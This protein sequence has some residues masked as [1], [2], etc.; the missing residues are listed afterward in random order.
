MGNKRQPQAFLD[1]F[2]GTEFNGKWPT[3]REL[4]HISVLRFPDN[5]CWS[6]AGKD[7]LSLT[8]AEA[9]AAVS[10]VAEYLLSTGIG[11]DSKVGVTGKNSPE[12]AIA[13]FAALYAGATVVPL[14]CALHPEELA[15]LTKFGDVDF[16]FADADKLEFAKTLVKGIASLEKCDSEKY[17]CRYILDLE[18]EGKVPEAYKQ[19]EEDVAAIL[20]TSGT[21]GN[22]KGVMLSN[23]NLVSCCL[24]AQYNLA[25][26]STDVLYAL[27]PIHHAYTLQADLL[28]SMCV[29]AHL[30]FTKRLV[31]SRI[32]KELKEEKVTVFLGVPMLFNKMLS[33]LMDGIQKKGK[34]TYGLV[35]AM[36]G[37]SGFLRDIFRINIGKVIFRNLL[38]KISLENIRICICGGGPL[39]ASTAKMYHRL[40]IDFVQGYGMTETSPI[41]HLNPKEAF[42]LESVGKNVEGIEQKIVDPDEDGNGLIYLRGPQVMKGYYKN[43]EATAEI[44]D[45][46]GWLNTG[47][48]GHIDANGYLYLT[49]RKKNIIVTDGGK[50]I[51][52]EEI[53]DMFQIYDDLEQVCVIGYCD[54]D[55]PEAEGVRLLAY[56]S[57][58]LRKHAALSKEKIR[59]EIN[60]IV[61]EVNKKLQSYKK[62]TSVVV[63]DDP[64]ET[65][66]TRKI[67]RASA[68]ALF[69]KNKKKDDDKDKDSQS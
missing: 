63:L 51:F 15:N 65:T 35:R 56:P 48:V 38:S 25:I 32:L 9:E 13:F 36:M 50:N 6:A 45:G 5:K 23:R 26:Y 1:A 60:R 30:V 34:I 44:I 42:V 64:L 46:E 3:L 18:A 20:F 29:G 43:P 40:G 31:V 39:P 16:I 68:I 22:P 49:G 8:Y 27:L 55:E 67:K 47:D 69:K 53:E 41:T 2:R 37:F 66:S 57:E 59:E 61:T 33:A 4:F 58:K 54:D 10:K 14:D 62:I 28:V 11:K 12:W 7:T 17:Q 21:T 52:P 24:L 19:T